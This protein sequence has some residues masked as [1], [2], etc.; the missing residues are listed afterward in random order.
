MPLEC[1]GPQTGDKAAVWRFMDMKKFRDFMANEEL[2]FC[3]ADLFKQDPNEGIPQDE[4]LR[5]VLGIRR[6]FL[7]DELKLRDAKGNLSQFRESS[8]ISCWHLFEG[9]NLAMWRDFAPYGVAVCTQ[10]GL[11]KR[12]LKKFVDPVEIGITQY[13]APQ[14]YNTVHFIFSKG[15]GFTAEK[16]VRIVF[17]FLRSCRR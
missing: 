9:E 10:Y 3:R 12:A 1:F 17:I 4:W 2:Y 14:R 8:F 11:L 13:H 5:S 7:E 16:E 6:G 15:S